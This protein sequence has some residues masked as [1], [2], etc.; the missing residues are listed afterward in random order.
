MCLL[1]CSF[2]PE[3]TETALSTLT[4][5]MVLLAFRVLNE[6][7]TSLSHPIYI[8]IFLTVLY[9]VFAVAVKN[10]LTINIQAKDSSDTRKATGL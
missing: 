10:V 4:V 9:A 3:I 5:A 1:R 8:A 6:L 2:A 7:R